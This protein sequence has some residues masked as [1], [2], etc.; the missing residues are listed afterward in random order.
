MPIATRYVLWLQPPLCSGCNRVCVTGYKS[1]CVQCGPDQVCAETVRGVVRA[2]RCVCVFGLLAGLGAFNIKNA[3]RCNIYIQSI[4]TLCVLCLQ[5]PLCSGCNRVCHR[6]QPIYTH[7]HTHTH[8][9]AHAHTRTYT[10]QVANHGGCTV[11][12]KCIQ[13][14]IYTHTHTTLHI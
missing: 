6:E 11:R 10:H 4:A 14:Y 5:P 9:V 7:T 12:R 8:Q 3:P 2:P 1:G 13:V